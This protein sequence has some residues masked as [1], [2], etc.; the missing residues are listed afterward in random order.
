MD[1]QVDVDGAATITPRGQ[2]VED[3]NG[4]WIR[5]SRTQEL[6]QA[7]AA[8][9]SLAVARLGLEYRIYDDGYASCQMTY[10]RAA[11]HGDAAKQV[12]EG[13]CQQVRQL[14]EEAVLEALGERLDLDQELE[15]TVALIFDPRAAVWSITGTGNAFQCVEELSDIS[16]SMS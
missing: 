14:V 9:A 4:T 1:V 7:L 5:I 3:G 13:A 2:F 8:V 10:R 6:Q 11:G 15:L 16:V 12:I